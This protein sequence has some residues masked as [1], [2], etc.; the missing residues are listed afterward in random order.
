MARK[1]R[2]GGRRGMRV[3]KWINLGF[4][5]LGVTVAAGPA[6]KGISDHIGDPANVPVAVLYNYTGV[7]TGNPAGGVNVP[8]LTSGIASILGGIALAKL[9]G[10]LGRRF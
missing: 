5:I 2:R 4:K 7:D 6:I 8:Q 3:G 10:F 9:G 1:R